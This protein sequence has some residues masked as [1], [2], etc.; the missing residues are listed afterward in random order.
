MF[1]LEMAE[2]L[3][4]LAETPTLGVYY[5]H[6][7]GRAIRRL[8]LPRS[9]Y[10]VYFTYDEDAGVLEVRAVWHAARGRRPSL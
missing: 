7:G 4:L 8:L 6:R 9:R 5:G 10:H 2:A 3:E 1:A